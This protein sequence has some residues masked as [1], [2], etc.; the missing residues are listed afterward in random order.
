MHM[1]EQNNAEIAN[2]GGSIGANL[3]V[4]PH[5]DAAMGEQ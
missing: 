3:V 4:S 5:S 2:I 1:D